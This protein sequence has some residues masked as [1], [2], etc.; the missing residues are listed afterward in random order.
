LASTPDEA[1]AVL[2]AMPERALH[3]APGIDYD[4][5]RLR[6]LA[7]DFQGARRD[8]ETALRR[9]D[10]IGWPLLRPRAQVL[11]G[12]LSERTG[13]LAAARRA[14]EAVIETW[15]ELR[16]KPVLANRARARLAAL[17]VH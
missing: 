7:G 9:C 15:G 6:A 4:I 13:D 14:Y 12:E 17:R 11:L 8:V 16:P 5:G 10:A 3:T 2:Q 1:K